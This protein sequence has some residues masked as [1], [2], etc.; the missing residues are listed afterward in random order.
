M[1]QALQEKLAAALAGR[2]QL[3]ERVEGETKE[4]E[5]RIEELAGKLERAQDERDRA[6]EVAENLRKEAQNTKA[7]MQK[8]V[9]QL[10]QVTSMKKMIQDKNAK[11]KELRDRLGKYEADV[12]GEDDEA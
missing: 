1:M 7:E 2:S 8:K 9:N 4:A 11:I 5:G 6:V 12:A 3:A 10:T